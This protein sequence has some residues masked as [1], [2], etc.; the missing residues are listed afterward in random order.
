M[1]K[2]IIAQA[3]VVLGIDYGAFRLLTW[4]LPAWLAPWLAGIPAL[5]GALIVLTM[6]GLAWQA[7]G[8]R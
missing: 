5:L 8:R 6:A 1:R 2:A 7:A 4:L 3:L